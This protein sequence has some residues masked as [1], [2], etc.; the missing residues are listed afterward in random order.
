MACN[1]LPKI[2]AHK[3]T[4]GSAKDL[5]DMIEVLTGKHF[6]VSKQADLIDKNGCLFRYG[7]GFPLLPGVPDTQFNP[8]SFC[9]LSANKQKFSQFAEDAGILSPIFYFSGFPKVFPVLI[10]DTL[11][12]CGGDGIHTACNED[13]FNEHIKVR[14]DNIYYNCWTPYFDT[15]YECRLYVAGEQITHAYYKVPFENQEQD[16][17]R[18]RSDYHFSYT[19]PEG[20]FRNLREI[21]HKIQK[22]TDGKF[23]SVDAG[24]IPERGEYI[25]FEINTGSWINESIGIPLAKYLIK[26]LSI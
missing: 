10:R 23:F 11:K 4:E 20:R 18:I 25:I 7:N 8:P 15:K 14:T 22:W 16:R 6:L 9:E 17:V 13:E 24:W 19:N 2:L 3:S 21:I 12:G 1:G 26:E 5:R